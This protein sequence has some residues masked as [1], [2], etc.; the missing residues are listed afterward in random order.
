MLDKLKI[1][2][3]MRVWFIGPILMLWIGIYLSGFDVVHWLIYVPATFALFA[4]LT[5]LCPGM[6]LIRSV[7]GLFK[8]LETS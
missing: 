4:F 8:S 3:E 6:L 5:G 2:T 7:L 1:S